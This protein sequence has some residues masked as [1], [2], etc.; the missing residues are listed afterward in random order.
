MAT[1]TVTTVKFRSMLA[2]LRSTRKKY[3]AARYLKDHIA[4]FNKTDPDLVKIDRRVNDFIMHNTIKTGD[5]LRLAVSKGPNGINVKLFEDAKKDEAAAAKP[6]PKQEAKPLGVPAE[7]TAG[8]KPP[9]VVAD[10]P[11][12]AEKKE[13]PKVQERPKAEEPRQ[14]SKPMGVPA[15]KPKKEKPESETPGAQQEK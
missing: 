15:E 7:K 10:K 2:G 9:G 14:E 4:R 3:K 8:S 6:A 5:A 12:A 1:P 11:K 13:K